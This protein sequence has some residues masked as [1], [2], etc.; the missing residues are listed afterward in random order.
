MFA[1]KSE[2]NND[3]RHAFAA[4]PLFA[5]NQQFGRGRCSKSAGPF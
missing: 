1:D 2:R 5:A 3:I 4:F